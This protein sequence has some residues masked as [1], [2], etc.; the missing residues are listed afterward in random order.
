MSPIT[1]LSPI[2]DLKFPLMLAKYN[3]TD[4]LLK[5]GLTIHLT[6]PLKYYILIYSK[7]QPIT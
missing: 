4:S 7:Q 1:S 6:N 3:K 2:S 5:S